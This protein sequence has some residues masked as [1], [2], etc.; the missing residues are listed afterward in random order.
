M[1][2]LPASVKIWPPSISASH[3]SLQTGW[4]FGPKNSGKTTPHGRFRFTERTC[5][6]KILPASEGTYNGPAV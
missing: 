2:M 4:I 6:D 3:G 5:I 1:E